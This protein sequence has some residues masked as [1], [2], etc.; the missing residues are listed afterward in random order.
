MKAIT[1]TIAFALLASA[2]GCSASHEDTQGTNDNDNPVLAAEQNLTALATT[3]VYN[4]TTKD[5]AITL[6]ANE[7]ALVMLR[8][9]KS[10]V[11]NGYT[12]NDSVT[13]AATVVD[14]TAVKTVV[15]TG[16]AGANGVII[17]YSGGSFAT[18]ANG[19]TVDLQGGTDTFAFRGTSTADTVV[20]GATSIK[21]G[22]A[23]NLKFTAPI[24]E[25]VIFMLGDGND[26]FNASGDATTGAAYGTAV[27]VY[28]GAGNDTFLQGTAA[29]PS[30][31]IYGGTGTDTVDY[32][33]RTA[34]ITVTYNQNL[35]LNDGL[36]GE[37]DSI[38]DDVDVVNGGTANDSLSAAGQITSEGGVTL[39]GNAGDD[40]LVGS[41]VLTY[42]GAG[43][44]TKDKLNGGAGDDT[45]NS[46][47]TG[48]DGD[49]AI[50]G[51]AGTDTISY[52]AR[53]VTGVTV[54]LA[55][56]GGITGGSEVD[57]YTV[58][59]ENIIGSAVADVITGNTLN[60]KITGGGGGDTLNGGAGADV[61]DQGATSTAG[62]TIDGGADLDTIDYRARTAAVTCNLSTG[63]GCGI[64]AEN[65]TIVINSSTTFA[66]VENV[67][68]STG[69]NVN[70]L[71]GDGNANELTGGTAADVINGG[72]G[73]DTIQTKN[74]GATVD[75]GA[76]ED[77]LLQSGAVLS[78]VST[79]CE[80]V[81]P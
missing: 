8:P 70:T 29:T 71:T 1:G 17:D 67:W 26:S 45:F 75:C 59:I 34:A 49:D 27:T 21:L 33:S 35:A 19:I 64:A 12:C 46:V 47:T 63:T 79:N 11:V 51:A 40:T 18:A 78:P 60:N 25:N 37:T 14:G 24:P 58:T 28:G 15:V 2:A 20:A 50:D 44:R 48:E 53:T 3:C 43:A 42:G 62:D 76:G 5:V 32:S 74:T 57:T 69:A 66:T 10:L 73:N 16:Q 30:E 55:T 41:G 36:A 65:D 31:T 4:A 80:V 68:G 13:A 61:F 38:N 6:A 39:N 72:G 54:N 81:M 7:T 77:I 9:D 22:T 23:A 56:S 52:S